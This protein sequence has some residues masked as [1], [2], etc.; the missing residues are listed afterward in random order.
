MFAGIQNLF[1]YTHTQ[2]KKYS[3]GDETKIHQ[4]L[5]SEVIQI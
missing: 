4:K 5:I 1:E 3:Y 2:K